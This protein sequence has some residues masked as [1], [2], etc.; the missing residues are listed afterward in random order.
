MKNHTVQLKK[1]E[2]E[3]KRKN[4]LFSQSLEPWLR[5]ALSLACQYAQMVKQLVHYQNLESSCCH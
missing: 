4:I 1:R 5:Q 2:T 3:K